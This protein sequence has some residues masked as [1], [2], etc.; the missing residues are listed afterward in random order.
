MTY[1]APK[2][3]GKSGTETKGGDGTTQEFSI[4]HGLGSVPSTIN[5]VPKSEDAS[6]DMWFNADASSI[7]VKYATAPPSGTDN[8]V[9]QWTVHY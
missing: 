3:E 4:A 5:V 7:V 6:A 2:Q 8:L 9:W 1:R